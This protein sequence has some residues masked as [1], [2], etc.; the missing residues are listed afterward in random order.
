[1][2]DN[3]D[4]IA[5]GL[6]EQLSPSYDNININVSEDVNRYVWRKLEQEDDIPISF[7][8]QNIIVNIMKGTKRSALQVETKSPALP[9]QAFVQTDHGIDQHHKC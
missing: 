1:M 8:T 5:E 6:E 3:A 4:T 9:S 7:T 2:Q